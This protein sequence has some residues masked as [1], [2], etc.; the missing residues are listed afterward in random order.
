MKQNEISKTC[1]V[2]KRVGPGAEILLTSRVEI[3]EDGIA[4]LQ[5][6]PHRVARSDIDPV[7]VSIQA[8]CS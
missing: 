6:G 5:I 1:R 2:I 7:C 8:S 3:A 4:V